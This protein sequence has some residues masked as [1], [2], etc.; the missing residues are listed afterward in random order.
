VKLTNKQLRQIIKEELEAVMEYESFTEDISKMKKVDGH[1][2][3]FVT[4]YR[5][6]RGP[7]GAGLGVGELYINV[8]VGEAGNSREVGDEVLIDNEA[9][10]QKAKEL[11][12]RLQSGDYRLWSG[13][14]RVGKIRE[15]SGSDYTSFNEKKQQAYQAAIEKLK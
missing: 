13:I 9:S 2:V 11:E 14:W 12:Q 4:V 1:A 10:S 7:T 15:K 6:K 8:S 3:Y 5:P